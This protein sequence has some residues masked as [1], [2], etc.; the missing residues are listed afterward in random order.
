MSN[1]PT[2]HEPAS[3]IPVIHECDLCVIGGSCTGLFAAIRAARLG[4]KVA[5]VEQANR[6]GGVAT[7]SMVNVWLS[8]RTTTFDRQIVGGLSTEVIARL[9]KQNQLRE[10]ENDCS[11]GCVFN[12]SELT[13][14]LDEMAHEAGLKI[15][16]H[17]MFVK[18]HVENNQLKAVIVENK[19]GRGA[20]R[21]RFFIDA[22][23][24]GDLA[25][26]LGLET[27]M[28]Q[29]W[30]PS[31]TC[32]HFAGW[33][34]LGNA[35][36]NALIRAHASEENLPMGFIWGQTIPNSDV[37]MIAGTRIFNNN[38]T[39]ADEFTAGEIEGR[40]QVRVISRILKKA[41]PESNL[42][43]VGLPQ[44]MGIR[45][46]R[47][48]RSYYKITG[49]DVL[50]G[51]QYEDGIANGSYRVDIHHQDKPGVT[52]RY[53][54]GS[55]T[56]LVPGEPYHQSRWRPE[57]AENPTF[58]Q[59]PYRTLVPQGPYGNLLVAGRMLDSDAEA[60][61]AL[62]VMVN[63]NQMGEAAGVAAYLA[64]KNNSTALQVKPKALRDTLR[65]G[66]SEII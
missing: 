55:Q 37:Y 59:I 3:E 18:P 62:R 47:H 9:K 56:Y 39:N 25:Y 45:D 14:E 35:D 27:Y 53:L 38:P 34:S 51:K 23:G 31:T 1:A 12:S 6:F 61:G 50:W 58:Y 43:L 10:S 63:L 52:F 5:I 19:S 48:V 4:L 44:R 57:T 22:S 21:A 32:A 24:D 11:V 2:L 15:Y 26:R 42:T 8:L 66:G 29:H 7:L 64:L 17:T 54:D 49:E 13:I 60:F 36:Y 65:E 30:N 41:V 28:E 16:F 20:I 40:R 46:T 33:N